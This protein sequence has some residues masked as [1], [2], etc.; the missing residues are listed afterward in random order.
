M[1]NFLPNG[2]LFVEKDKH[3][4]SPCKSVQVWEICARK[5]EADYADETLVRLNTLICGGKH[6]VINVSA[7]THN[8]VR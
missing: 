3:A 5:A 8:F 4:V 1:T 2:A 6:R 7:D